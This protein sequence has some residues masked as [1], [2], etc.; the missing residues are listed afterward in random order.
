MKTV[1]LLFIAIL[2]CF[3][4]MAQKP[5]V[6]EITKTLKASWEKAQT[7]NQEK[8][9]IN[10]NSI[11]IGASNISTSAQQFDGVPKGALITFAKI[12]FIQN[13]FFSNETQHTHRIMTA[14]IY[15]D[16]FGDWQIKNAGTI[17]PDK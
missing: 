5:T 8:N 11:K 6:D 17:Y 9:T 10:I 12:D 3:S 15:K 13:Q 2:F 7:A 16:Q 14:W 1:T 4:C